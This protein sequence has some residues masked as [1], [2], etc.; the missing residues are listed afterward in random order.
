M[1]GRAGAHKGCM[2]LQL[3]RSEQTGNRVSSLPPIACQPPHPVPLSSLPF[4]L[5]PLPPEVPVPW[6]CPLAF[7]KV[8]CTPSVL[9]ASALLPGTLL[10][11]DEP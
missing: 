9:P 10:N 4:A 3:A 2:A 1:A 5:P 11:T 8:Y 6:D 7:Q